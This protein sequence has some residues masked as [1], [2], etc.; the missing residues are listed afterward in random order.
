MKEM[1]ELAV[2]LVGNHR[3]ETASPN[4]LRCVGSTE[5]EPGGFEKK[6]EEVEK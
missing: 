1:R 3:A 5:K 4:A 6:E 2:C